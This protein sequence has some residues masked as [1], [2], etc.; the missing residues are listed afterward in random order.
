MTC[1][2]LAILCF[3]AGWACAT[4]VAIIVIRNERR[5]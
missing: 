5:R 1:I 3:S 4:V 2:P